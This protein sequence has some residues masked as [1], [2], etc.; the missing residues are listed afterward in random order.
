[1]ARLLSVWSPN[2]PITAFRRRSASPGARPAE[3]PEPFALVETVKSARRLAA[4]SEAAHAA[5]LYPFQTVADALAL[6]PGLA[7][8]EA[9]PEADLK[10]LSGLADWCVRFSPAVA[11]DPPDGL[12]LD[13]EGCAGLWGGEQ[14]M[15][16]DLALRLGRAGVPARAAVADTTGAAWALARFGGGRT[17]APKGS[18]RTLIEPLPIEAL[19]LEPA[20]AETLIVLGIITVGALMA[21]PRAELT[22]RFGPWVRLRLDQALGEVEEA[23]VFRR[24][25]PPFFE[26][27]AFAEPIS[28]PED[29]ARVSFDVTALLCRRLDA[30]GSGARRFELAFHRLDGRAEILRV[31][32]ALASRDARR[33]AR[34]F[35]PKLETV[36]PGFGVEAVTLAADRVERVAEKQIAFAA[37]TDAANDDDAEALVDRLSNRLGEARVWRPSS[38]ES[39][40]PERAVTR[41]AP[42]AAAQRAWPRDRPRPVRLFRRPE[43]IEALAEVPDNPPALFRWRGRVHRVRRAEGPERLAQEWWRAP[44]DETGP[45]KVRDYYR[46]E[47]AEGRRFWIFRAGLY[48]PGA[49]PRWWLHG[50][51]G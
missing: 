31:G 18:I 51:F 2:W 15:L 3:P 28:T 39:W 29:L 20:A 4:V 6:E 36:D 19:R 13:I 34:L 22:R 41:V 43:P 24:P 5:G 47:D 14:A 16:D 1:M 11:L 26:R 35:A 30:A 37:E 44:E 50:L 10:A 32:T 40:L 12:L 42:L 33:I 8:F 48:G 23:L 49:P 17:V 9:D 45:D 7:T 25:A 46:V 38:H 21:L 27:L